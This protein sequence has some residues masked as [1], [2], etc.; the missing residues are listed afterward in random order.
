MLKQLLDGWPLA[1]QILH[2]CDGTGLEAR[3]AKTRALRPK[4]HAAS[5]AR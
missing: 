1:Q 3:S 4:H 2:G 5:A